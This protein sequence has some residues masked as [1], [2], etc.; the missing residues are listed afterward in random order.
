MS[1]LTTVGIF[2]DITQTNIRKKFV[3]VFVSLNSLLGTWLMFIMNRKA[4]QS[5][6]TQSA[7]TSL[8]SASC[9]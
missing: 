1:E 2:C 9:R 4:E 7:N 5:H 3:T 6:F 8:S